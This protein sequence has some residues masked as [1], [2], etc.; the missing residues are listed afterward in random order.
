M[1]VNRMMRRGVVRLLGGGRTAVHV[2]KS[3]S[4]GR[5]R[6]DTHALNQSNEH[7]TIPS[8]TSNKS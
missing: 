3:S 5:Q 1:L 7:I 8:F 6:A 2:S 4:I